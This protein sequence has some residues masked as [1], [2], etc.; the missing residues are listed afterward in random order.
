MFVFY[1]PMFSTSEVWNHSGGFFVR[2]DSPK[3]RAPHLDDMRTLV[4]SVHL[5][6]GRTLIHAAAAASAEHG[7]HSRVG[8]TAARAAPVSDPRRVCAHDADLLGRTGICCTETPMVRNAFNNGTA[9]DT[10][11]ISYIMNTHSKHISALI[12]SCRIV[13]AFLATCENIVLAISLF[14]I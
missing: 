9:N 2:N 8:H 1:P 7:R 4:V 14:P 6:A 3:P 11:S 13:L 12:I 10:Y 5:F